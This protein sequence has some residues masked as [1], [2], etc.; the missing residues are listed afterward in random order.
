MS[1]DELL[2]KLKNENC[3]EKWAEVLSEGD[4]EFVTGTWYN[5][6]MALAEDIEHQM[7]DITRAMWELGMQA[8]DW[9]RLYE[10]IVIENS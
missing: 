3:L 10:L 1:P 2:K 4:K 7:D 8:F 9:E 6:V 5:F